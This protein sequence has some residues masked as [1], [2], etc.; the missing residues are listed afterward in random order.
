MFVSVCVC[1]CVVY[2]LSWVIAWLNNMA[3]KRFI[4][5]ASY[6]HNRAR[7]RYLF[8][9]YW[10]NDWPVRT[11]SPP[12]SSSSS[13][14]S[15]SNHTIQMKTMSCNMCKQSHRNCGY[16]MSWQFSFSKFNFHFPVMMT[17][18]FWTVRSY[19]ISLKKIIVWLI[20]SAHK[21]IWHLDK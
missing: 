3:T 21:L 4:R 12:P 15:L 11:P 6:S 17:R 14:M 2:E 10:M 9:C 19:W 1:V 18:Y 7:H 20:L 8:I 16:R 5:A 13:S